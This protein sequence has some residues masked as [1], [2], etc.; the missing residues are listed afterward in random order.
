MGAPDVERREQDLSTKVPSFPGAIGAIVIDAKKG[1]VNV[2]RLVTSD[3]DFLKNYTPDERIEVG[4][5]TSHFSALAYLQKSNKLWVVRAANAAL[6]GGAVLEEV[7]SATDNAAL[8][9]G[10]SDPTTYTFAATETVLL[11]GANPGVWNNSIAVLIHNYKASEG[12]TTT[13][14]SDTLT[15]A[16]EYNDGEAVIVSN[17]GGLLP[18]PLAV[19][20]VYYAIRVDAVTIKLAL[21]FADAIAGTEI[22]LIDDGTGTHSIRPAVEKTKEPGTFLIE[23]YKKDSDANYTL[24]ESWV[25]SRETGK[26]DGNGRNTYVETVLEGSNYIRAFDN[27]LISNTTLPKPQL[28]PL[29]LAEGS[30]G[31]TVADSHMILALDTLSNPESHFATLF[32]DGGW[33]TA[34]YQQ[35]LIT[36]C[37]GRDDCFATLSTP[38]D[39]EASADYIN[40]IIDYRKTIL[41]A[42]TSYAELVSPHVKIYDKFN[43]RQIFV[44][45]DGYIAALT[46]ATGENYE[47]WYPA[48]GFRRGIITVLDVRRRFSKGE[49]DVLY[50]NGINPIRF[51]PGKGI[52]AWGQK[53]LLARPSALDRKNVRMLLVVIKP[54][55]AEALED[56]IMEINDPATRSIV[57]ATIDSYMQDI[58]ARRGV[59]DFRVKCDDD[60]NTEADVAANR[61]NV[62]LFIKPSQSVEFIKFTTVIVG[63]ELSF[64][65]AGQSV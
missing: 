59:T 9:A 6:F 7:D 3:T 27:T 5:G 10:E 55:I 62:D 14:A 15:V 22:T 65:L 53:T 2:P 35:A 31:G 45:Q 23:V 49:M 13:F 54:A 64:E 21:T 44:P 39:K 33:A 46:S 20:T 42:N 18:D 50:D 19:N 4:Y 47:L 24:V 30:D 56:F 34:P 60:N 25:C 41:N 32:M 11:Y 48:A 12:F 40:E 58:K 57:Q 36:L 38:Y 28:T 1:E 8:P 61:M 29:D 16:Q 63:A 26:K 37:E 52:V 51:A 43:D 17:L